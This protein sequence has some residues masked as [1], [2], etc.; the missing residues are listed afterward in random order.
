[1]KMEMEKLTLKVNIS[2]I[3]KR[4]RKEG[5]E[6]ERKWCHGKWSEITQFALYCIY[7]SNVFMIIKTKLTTEDR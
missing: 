4:E 3:Y 6:K 2:V 1:M 7:N 5:G